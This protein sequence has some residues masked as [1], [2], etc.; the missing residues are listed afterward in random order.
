MNY[1]KSKK[2]IFIVIG[3]LALVMMLGAFSYAFFNYTRSGEQNTVTT[4]RISFNANQGAAITLTNV[5][6]ISSAEAATD[7]TN[8][9]TAAITVTGDTDFT[10]GLEY[11]VTLQDVNLTVGSGADTKTLPIAI[12]ISVENNGTGSLGTAE[13]GDYY[14]NRNSYTASKYKVEYD[15]TPKEGGH[16]LVGYI[17][18][19]TT[20]GT[21][22]GVNGIINIKAY[23]DSSKIQVVDIHSSGNNTPVNIDGGK[24]TFTLEE[25]NSIQGQNALSFK[26]KVESNKGIW[27]PAPEQSSEPSNPSEPDDFC[28]NCKFMFTTDISYYGGSNQA[29]EVS[30]LTGVTDDYTT[31]NKNIFLGFTEVDGRIDRAYAC[32]IKGEDP[33]NGVAFCIEGALSDTRGGNAA[34]REAAYNANN[35]LLNDSTTGLW[36]GE[37]SNYNSGIVCNGSVT[38]DSNSAGGVY[39]S[40]GSSYCYVGAYGDLACA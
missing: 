33:N 13:T 39:I 37:C 24:T 31:L 9:K 34:T 21:I 12:E 6:P 22:E 4:G 7:T 11:V 25:W 30:T 5:Y 3:S 28:P 40:E 14:A 36:Q 23:I 1:I 15:G 29:T 17:A 32:G 35:T 19:N 38:A 18:P 26:I 8:A 20:A 16:I 2:K 27:V 10:G